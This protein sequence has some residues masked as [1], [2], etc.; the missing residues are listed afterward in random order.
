M[1]RTTPRHGQGLST[2]ASR[3]ALAE[4]LAD[5]WPATLAAEIAVTGSVALGLADDDSDIE[6]N[7][8]VDHLPSAE[9]RAAFIA[10]VGGTDAIAE[11]EP[12]GAGTFATTFRCRDMWVETAWMT[13]AVVDQRLRHLL[14]GTASNGVV[15]AWVIT[16]ALPLRTDGQLGAWRQALQVYPDVLQERIIES[17]TAVYHMRHR[18]ADRWTF[19]RRRQPLALMQRLN[20]DIYSVLRLLFALNRRWEPDF[21]WL[22]H[23]TRDL[24]VAPDRLTERVEAIFTAP[25]L[26]QR[27][28]TSLQL[29]ADTLALLPPTPS[30]EQARTVVE[31]TIRLG[32]S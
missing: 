20:L 2:S 10:A 1:V 26:E 18:V 29:I 11:P 31:E 9:E 8:W 27:V 22:R 23:V 21:K 28:A 25:E 4:T 3:H 7:L 14:A 24:A 30:V 19:C 16:H 12:W 5:A 13:R 17:R 6:L 15:L 32:S